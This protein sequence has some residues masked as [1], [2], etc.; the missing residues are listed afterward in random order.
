VVA[1]MR[2]TCALTIIV[3]AIVG[4]ALM[5]IDLTPAQLAAGAASAW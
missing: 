1:L 2:I 3:A 4:A 5:E